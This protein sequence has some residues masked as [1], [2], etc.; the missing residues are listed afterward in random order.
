LDR[1][2]EGDSL[3]PRLDNYVFGCD[4]ASAASTPETGRMTPDRS[5]DGVTASPPVVRF[6]Q[7]IR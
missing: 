7:Q 5:A 6:P 3:R 2:L 1:H 4:E